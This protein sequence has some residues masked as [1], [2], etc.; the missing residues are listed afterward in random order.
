MSTLFF[1]YVPYLLNAISFL[2][3][4]PTGRQGE[5]GC[6]GNKP[7]LFESGLYPSYNAVG[8]FGFLKPKGRI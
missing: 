2:G 1:I 4:V 6:S 3:A 7:K 5:I 8:S